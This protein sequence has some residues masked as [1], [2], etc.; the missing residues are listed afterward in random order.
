MA[1]IHEHE[2]TSNPNQGK[3]PPFMKGRKAPNEDARKTKSEAARRRL[4]MM[5]QKKSKGN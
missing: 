2:E 1:D 5:T 4:A 3:V